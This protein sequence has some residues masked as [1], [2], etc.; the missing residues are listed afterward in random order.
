VDAEQWRGPEDWAL[1]VVGF[2]LVAVVLCTLIAWAHKG[3]HR[4]D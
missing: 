1:V 4:R 2:F 3:R